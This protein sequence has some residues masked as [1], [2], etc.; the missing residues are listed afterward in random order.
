MTSL[1]RRAI[2]A[3]KWSAIDVLMRQGVQFIASVVLARIL[4]PE[5]FGVIAMLTLFIGV[6]SVF[7][8]SGF[9]SALIQRQSTTRLEESAVFYFNLCAGL[10]AAM[11]LCAA[12][13]W[14]AE[15]FSEPRLQSLTYLMSFT[16][17]AGALG[18]I[19]TTL[20]T[21]E[22]NFRLLAGIGIASTISGATVAIYMASQ[23]FGVW[24]LAGNTLVS[25]VVTVALLWW[26]H[27]WRPQSKFSMD[28]LR[29]YFGFGGYV[30]A[31]SLTDAIST[32]LYV[33]L[34]GRLYSASD[35]GFYNRAQ[36]TQ[37]LPVSLMT[38]IINR[39]A[40]TT[41]SSVKEDK[42]R[43]VRGLRQAQSISMLL[44]IPIMLG[45]TLLAEPLVLTLFGT[46]WLPSVPILQVLAL[47]G[48][49]WPMHVLNLN[50]L[51]AQGRSDLNFWIALLKK[52]V[53]ISVTVVASFQ[54]VLAIA[55]AQVVI[56]IFAYVVNT[57]YTKVLLGY[58]GWKQLL[59]QAKIVAAVIPM[60][61]AIYFLK[62]M[63]QL[64]AA[65]RLAT[66]VVIGAA[67]YWATCRVMCK[68]LLDQ[69]IGLLRFNK[70]VAPKQ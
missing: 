35:L 52:S 6:A 17:F 61:A 49:L 18:S 47:A 44:N 30:M 9:S 45:V 20:L 42:D 68:E 3:T 21:K 19:H 28:A 10:A 48:L 26:F 15:F 33:I 54:G 57:H 60:A 66:L 37:Q 55:W 41:F 22:M 46:Q 62:D 31:A 40:F 43:L 65:V 70:N 11:T 50:I 29:S 32:N 2:G 67:I 64:S 14:I 36:N 16:L 56:S 39:V 5:E 63:L 25:T 69:F 4:A 51:K 1:Q 53:S 12:A 27:P 23:G 8:D 34:I 59:H 38:N 24:S 58:G 13:P 7:I